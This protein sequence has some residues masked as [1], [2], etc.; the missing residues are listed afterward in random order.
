M[1]QPE[2]GDSLSFANRILQEL[3]PQIPTPFQRQPQN[4]TVREEAF[5]KNEIARIMQKVPIKK[6]PGY[7]GIDFIVL[8]TIFRT[9]PDILI[10]FYNKCLS[11]QCF[12]NPLKTGVIVLFLKKGKNKSDIKSYRPVSLLPTLGKI[13]EKL[14]L[15]R[16]NHHL[17]RN[18]LQHPNQYGFR[19]N[20]STEEAILDLLD[21]INS[22][23]NSNQHALMISLDIKG[24]FD[25]L[26]Y[27]SIKNSLDNL[28]YHSNTL[29]TLIDILSNRKVA[30]NT[31][32]GPAT[33]NQ[34]QGCPQGSC[35]GP[36]FWN[37]VAD[38]V[39]QQDWPQGVHL[40]AFA[41][42]F[43]FL[44]NAGSK[45]EV[46]NLA[47]KA[48]QTFKTWTDKHK[49]E[50]SLDKTYYLHINKNR[51][52]PIWYSGIKWGQNNIKRASVIKYLGVLIDDKLNFAAH[53]SAI[54]N[55]SLILHQGLKNVAS[56]SW[57]LSKNI[58]RQLYLT[59][60]WKRSFSMPQ[61]HGP[62]TSLLD[63]RDSCV[64]SKESFCSI[65]QGRTTPPQRRLS[66]S[67]KV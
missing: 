57:G 26:Q 32:Q 10:T 62:T 51:S 54:K 15:E 55:K 66:R 1:D 3:Y 2:E 61:Q 42:D 41:D 56:T 17:R 19:T 64:L 22:A 9:N 37:L 21:K 65:S 53:L 27:T 49:L 20:R 67:S 18:N 33:W 52:G 34:Q 45:Q 48:L 59:R 31:S 13:L 23:K 36:A 14:L 11:L 40:Q 24:A 6:A 39:L 12:P 44:V 50:I 63:N 47:N 60:W 38:E 5:T 46:K 58:R 29:E 25:H 16:L 4:Q 43:V 7:D 8:K 35:T 30:I 28:K